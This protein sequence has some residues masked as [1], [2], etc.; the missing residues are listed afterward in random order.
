MLFAPGP[1]EMDEAVCQVAARRSLPYFRAKPFAETVKKVSADIAWLFETSSLPLPIA[2]SGTG[3]MEMA[4]TNLLDP[5]DTAV[6]IN[7]GTFGQRWVDICRAFQ[8]NVREVKVELGRTPDLNILSEN[9]NDGADAL[10]V[11]MHETSTGYL[12]D[13]EAIGKVMQGRESLFVVDG[14]SSIGADPFRMDAWHVDCALVSTQKALALMP[15]LGHI[16]FNERAM[17]RAAR[18]KRG[19]YYFNAIDYAKNMERGMTPFTPAMVSIL[20][21]EERM[22]Q[23]RST[24]IDKWVSRHA[25]FATLFRSRMLDGSD[26]FGMFPER[27]SNAMS[28]ITLPRDVPATAIVDYMRDTYDWWFAPNPTKRNDYLRISHMGDISCETTVLVA[29]RLI[30]TVQRLRKGYR[31]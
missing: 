28:A 24:G 23:I 31:A 3:L 20:Q 1:V 18:V 17:E 6:V 14:V 12:Y 7:G 4:V 10:L 5:G 11:N 29:E 21:V 30:D 25:E 22:K 19:R 9:M 2:A 13:I 16:A 27:S 8:V 26:E 15:G